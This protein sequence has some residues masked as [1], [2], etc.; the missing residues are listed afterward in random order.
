MAWYI[1]IAIAIA[2]AIW[3]KWGQNWYYEYM[4]Y[5]QNLPAIKATEGAG[6]IVGDIVGTAGEIKGVADAITHGNGNF[7]SRA[8][9]AFSSLVG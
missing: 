9:G 3:I 7:F 2:V 8:T 6:K 4:L 1:L 5:R